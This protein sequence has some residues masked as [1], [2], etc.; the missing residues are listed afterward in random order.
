MSYE[1]PERLEIGGKSYEIRSDYRAI[2]DICAALSDSEL[3]EEE[4]AYEVLQIFYPDFAEIPPDSHQEAIE[5][6]LDFIRGER[7]GGS[8]K[9]PGLVDWN[10]DFHL[11][12]G[13][14]NRIIGQEIR[15]M[16]YL[17]WWTFLSAYYEIGDCLFSQVIGIREKVR[18][19][20]KLDPSERQFY[21]ENPDLIDSQP[22]Y[23]KE[24][25]EFMDLLRKPKKE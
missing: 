24:E 25:Q 17:H 18:K 20:K 9:G 6:C 3:S 1:L 5:K 22:R 7:S 15:S 10:K 19:G 2:L 12:A 23:T 16:S 21:R 8:S 11:I 14:V 4:R 13:P